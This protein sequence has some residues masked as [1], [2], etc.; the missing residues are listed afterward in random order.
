MFVKICGLTTHAA[1]EAAIDAGADAAGFVFADSV[2]EISPERAAALTRGASAPV[3]K[4][5]VMRHPSAERF[6]HVVETFAPD[7]IQSDAEDLSLLGLP[8]GVTALPVYRSGRALPAAG[9]PPRLLYESAVSGSGRRAD[10][11]EA[12]ALAADTELVLAGGLSPDNVE[13]AIREVGPWGVDVSSGVE[14]SPGIKDP[15][16]IHAFVARVRAMEYER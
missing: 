4:V 13:D 11:V 16:K 7:W 9:L 8:E 1:L 10:W 2:R 3:L 14:G 5:A 15:E 12:R 6:A